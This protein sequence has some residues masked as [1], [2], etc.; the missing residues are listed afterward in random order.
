VNGELIMQILNLDFLESELNHV[1]GAGRASA[2]GTV[3][4]KAFG[5]LAWGRGSSTSTII[6]TPH[7]IYA[8]NVSIGQVWSTNGG[9]V[10]SSS[11]SATIVN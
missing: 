1:E 10:S 4:I 6:E 3:S 7:G 9:S 8:S 11:S 2:N 5:D